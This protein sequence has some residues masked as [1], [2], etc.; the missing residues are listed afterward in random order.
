M[1]STKRH[2]KQRID[3]HLGVSSRTNLSI[4]K[5]VDSSIYQ[6]HILND[7]HFSKDQFK[8]I[9]KTSDLF[10]LRILESIHIHLNKPKLNEQ[11]SA[12]PLH[13]TNN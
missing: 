12:L 7:H 3:E 4:N 5:K 8:I 1:G 9:D 13:I 11:G 6:H 2:F 10:E